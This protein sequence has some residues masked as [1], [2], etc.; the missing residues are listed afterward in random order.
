MMRQALFCAAA[1]SALAL[2]ACNRDDSETAVGQ[3][4][5][6]NAAQDAA[7]AAVGMAAGPMAATSTD[8]FVTAAAI[9]DMYEVAAGK[10]ASTKGTSAGVKAFGKMMVDGHTATT[11]ELMPLAAGAGLTPPAE[12]DERRKGFVDNLKAASAADFDKVYLDQQ[13]AAHDEALSLLKGYADGGDNAGIKAFAAKT[14]PAVEKHLAEAKA[15]RDGGPM[16]A[17]K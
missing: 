16:P 3:S 8:G 5:P 1:L 9:S 14:A 10:L 17:H 15:L 6:V 2:S 13:V 4:E 12:M 7:G 11:K